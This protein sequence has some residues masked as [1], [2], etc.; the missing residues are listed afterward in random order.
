[1]QEGTRNL[2]YFAYGAHMSEDEMLRAFPHARM[3]GL[4]RLGG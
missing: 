2:L 4:A 3:A 1:M